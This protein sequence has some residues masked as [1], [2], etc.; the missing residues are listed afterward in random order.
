MEVGEGH[1]FV[2]EKQPGGR[3]SLGPSHLT[4]QS[5][6]T[7]P[8]HDHA[9]SSSEE[10]RSTIASCSKCN[11]DFAEFYNGWQ[12]ITVRSASIGSSCLTLIRKTGIVLP[13]VSR[14]FVSRCRLARK[15][16]AKARCCRQCSTRLVSTSSHLCHD[17][18]HIL[19]LSFLS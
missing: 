11:T 15:R 18:W 6:T 16:Q 1:A 2:E 13:S 14:S 9:E 3:A 7:T 17:N 8:N 5:S 10:S 4:V 12:Q 19:Y